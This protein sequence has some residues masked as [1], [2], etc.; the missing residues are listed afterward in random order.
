MTDTT[1]HR[2]APM[3]G[4]YTVVTVPR[5]TLAGTRE[6]LTGLVRFGA[7]R[8]SPPAGLRQGCARE[9]DY[10]IRG[11]LRVDTATGSYEIAAGDVVVADPDEPHATTALEDSEIFFVLL[12]PVA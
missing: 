8:R 6:A 7:G 4:D 5:L 12:D 11:R 10:V 3:A 1:V 2:F 9:I